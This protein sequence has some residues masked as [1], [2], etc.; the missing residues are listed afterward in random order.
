[1][2][3]DSAFWDRI[4]PRYARSRISDQESYDRK[5]AVTREHLTPD[6][7]MLEFG[8]GTGSTAILHAPFARQIT[9]ID[10]SGRMLEI[11]RGKTEDADI[12]NLSFRQDS[13]ESFDAAGRTWDVIMGHSI[14][15]LLA[16][17]KTAIGK[18]HDLLKPGGRFITSTPCLSGPMSWLKP[19]LPVARFFGLVPAVAF[20]TPAELEREI[21]AAGFHIEHRW[22]PGRTKALFLIAIKD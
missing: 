19:V 22:Q 13:I 11:A 7:D 3:T 14:L 15:H 12:Q 21:I 2:T 8:C 18:V 1:M 9:A 10:I 6:T 5:I 4:A 16:D 17:R 20:F